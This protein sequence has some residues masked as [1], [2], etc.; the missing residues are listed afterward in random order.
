M[1]AIK[2]NK[3]TINNSSENIFSFLSDLNNLEK[4]MPEGK[5][6][7]WKSTENT[8]QFKISGMGTLGMKIKEK[9]AANKIIMSSLSDK[10]FSFEITVDIVPVEAKS[11][12]QFVVDANINTFMLMMVEKPLTNFFNMMNEKL[13][14]LNA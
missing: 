9:I 1:S 12:V 7:D 5:V 2:S 14:Q 10:P 3:I 13:Q 8:C 6:S 4:L 11:E